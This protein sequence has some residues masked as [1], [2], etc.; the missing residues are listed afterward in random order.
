MT[1]NPRSRA[2]LPK[3]PKSARTPRTDALT[4]M[5]QADDSKGACE[6]LA[7]M[8]EHAEM[9]EWRMEGNQDKIAVLTLQIAAL[10]KKSKAKQ[11]SA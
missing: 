4:A 6:C 3:K 1:A 10:E 7:E 9:L 2:R 8:T 11:S 5:L